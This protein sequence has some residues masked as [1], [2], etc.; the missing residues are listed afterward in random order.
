MTWPISKLKWTR[1]LCY[2]HDRKLT[3]S[4]QYAFC[5]TKFQINLREKMKC[6]KRYT[7]WNNQQWQS[8]S[9][10]FMQH[11]LNMSLL[12]I[13]IITHIIRY[14]VGQKMSNWSY[15]RVVEESFHLLLPKCHQ[16]LNFLT[17]QSLTHC[18]HQQPNLSACRTTRCV[19]IY[20]F[21]LF[22]N[23]NL[24]FTFKLARHS[25]LDHRVRKS[26][27]FAWVRIWSLPSQSS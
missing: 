14:C 6:N 20:H 17:V 9:R 15:L 26:C 16:S 10:L 13:F 18:Y 7:T 27:Q 21:I 22:Y 25:K 24:S 23:T 5:I 1:H 11:I 8:K 2:N 4:W 19:K 3:S 12:I